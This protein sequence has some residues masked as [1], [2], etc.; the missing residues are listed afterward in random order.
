MLVKQAILHCQW[1]PS[2]CGH[3]SCK[4]H[5][6][7]RYESS[8][9][10]CACPMQ[11]NL[12]IMVGLFV[13]AMGFPALLIFPVFLWRRYR[14]QKVMAS[15]GLNAPGLLPSWRDQV[16]AP[17][18]CVR[19]GQTGSVTS[20]GGISASF[21]NLEPPASHRDCL[22]F[23]LGFRRL[24]SSHVVPMHSALSITLS[25]ILSLAVLPHNLFWPAIQRKQY[26]TSAV[27]M[28]QAVISSVAF[29]GP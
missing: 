16:C 10:A 24:A 23:I 8:E 29:A 6:C 2:T 9:Q 7:T 27:H 11:Y 20:W 25:D 15:G 17:A 26:S 19:L 28:L 21:R 5:H 22:P 1:R 3:S 14:S 4:L 13:G 12:T 18:P